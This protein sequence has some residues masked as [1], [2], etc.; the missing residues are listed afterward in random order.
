MAGRAYNITV[1]S[2]SQSTTDGTSSIKDLQYAARLPL[3]M[4]LTHASHPCP[5]TGRSPVN[6]SELQ[7]VN[8]RH[9]MLADLVIVVY[10]YILGSQAMLLT[11]VDILCPLRMLHHFSGSQSPQEE[12]RYYGL[13]M[14][15]SHTFLC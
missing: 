12:C 8:K 5:R 2:Y 9:E 7:T 14:T 15:Y 11:Q 6:V 1:E 13:D 3:D 4:P 10:G